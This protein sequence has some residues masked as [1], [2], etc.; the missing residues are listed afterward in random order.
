[1]ATQT[2][3]GL[4][5]IVEKTKQILKKDHKNNDGDLSNEIYNI[6]EIYIDDHKEM[7]DRSLFN[8]NKSDV[9]SNILDLDDNTEK[10]KISEEEKSSYPKFEEVSH[11]I[12]KEK[13]D[14]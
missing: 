2:E 8:E 13:S 3:E 4:N 14:Q 11:D 7:E 10:I 1:M 12:N 9:A 5:V 6:N